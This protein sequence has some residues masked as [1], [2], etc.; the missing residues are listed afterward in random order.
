MT[1]YH[2]LNSYLPISTKTSRGLRS[3]SVQERRVP[4]RSTRRHVRYWRKSTSSSNQRYKNSKIVHSV[5]AGVLVL[6]FIV[7]IMAGVGF[8][9]LW[10]VWGGVYGAKLSVGVQ[11]SATKQWLTNPVCWLQAYLLIWAQRTTIILMWHLST[12]SSQLQISLLVYKNTLNFD[13]YSNCCRRRNCCVLTWSW[14]MRTKG[15]WWK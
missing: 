4:I 13:A 8:V 11:T 9:V 14:R 3:K 10:L 12:N 15:F 2:S 7:Y 1:L 6:G 5:M